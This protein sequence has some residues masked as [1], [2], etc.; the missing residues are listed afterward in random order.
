MS[1]LF[2]SQLVSIKTNGYLDYLSGLPEAT[3]E[4]AKLRF[5]SM[6]V[7]MWFYMEAVDG[8]RKKV[9]R[10]K[11]ISWIQLFF[12]EDSLFPNNIYDE[13]KRKKILKNLMDNETIS[14]K[15]DSIIEYINTLPDS[16]RNAFFN[17][18]CLIVNLDKQ[19]ATK[20]LQFLE[21]FAKKIT[22]K[23]EDKKKM[24]SRHWI[25]D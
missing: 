24:F 9:E 3:R 5:A 12:S 4:E 13:N 21:E 1:A 18:A 2:T 19:I 8:Y 7:S 17:D 16:I 15:I 22:I 11:I 14:I 10:D 25:L 20:E 23:S 6:T